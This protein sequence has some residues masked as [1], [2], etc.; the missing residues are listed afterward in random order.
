MT[1]QMNICLPALFLPV[2]NPTRI[3]RRCFRYKFQCFIGMTEKKQEMTMKKKYFSISQNKNMYVV[4]GNG[5]EIK[6]ICNQD[7]SPLIQI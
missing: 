4:N 1:N 7:K 2:C 3:I 5:L 6:D